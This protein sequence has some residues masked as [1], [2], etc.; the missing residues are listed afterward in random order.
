MAGRFRKARAWLAARRGR[1]VFGVAALLVPLVA[2]AGAVVSGAAAPLVLRLGLSAL[3]GAFD[4]HFEISDLR[5]GNLLREIELVGVRIADLDGRPVIEVDSLAARFR[6][7]DLLRKRIRVHDVDVWGA[8]VNIEQMHGESRVNLERIFVPNDQGDGGGGASNLEVTLRSVR[9]HGANLTIRIPAEA[10]ADSLQK[11]LETTPDGALL[12]RVDVIGIDAEVAE[13]RIRG[14]GLVGE[15]VDL[16][17]LDA[18][19]GLFPTSFRLGDLSG[20]VKHAGSRVSIDDGDV[21][22]GSSALAASGWVDWG[23][24]GLGYD[25]DLSSRRFDPADFRFFEPRLPPGLGQVRVHAYS[26]GEESSYTVTDLQLALGDSRLTGSLAV[27][28]GEELRVEG[29]DLEAEPLDL[30]LLEPWTGRALPMPMRAQGRVRLDGPLERLDV[31]GRFTLESPEGRFRPSTVQLD[32]R[33]LAEPPYGGF[34]LSV[35]A[36][37]LDLALV[38]ALWPSFPLEGPALVSGT[39]NGSLGGPVELDATFSHVLGPADT[40]R[41]R[42][43]GSITADNDDPVLNGRLELLGFRLPSLRPLHDVFSADVEAWGSLEL[44]GALSD[45]AIE[46]NLKTSAG[47]LRGTAR[48]NLMEPGEHYAL[49][50]ELEGIDIGAF[51][52]GVGSTSLFGHLEAEA[53]GSDPA[54]LTGRVDVALGPSTYD[55]L[56]V[57][58]LDAELRLGDGY[59]VVEEA[60]AIIEGT[61]ITADGTVGLG[62]G[63]PAG[64]LSFE[65]SAVSIAFLG[66]LLGLV[67]E[68][69]DEPAGT[70]EDGDDAPAGLDGRAR[71]TG[72]VFASLPRVDVRGEAHVLGASHS[73]I[74]VDSTH[75]AFVG[76]DVLGSERSLV[77][78]AELSSGSLLARAFDSA[79]VHADYTSRLVEFAVDLHRGEERGAEVAGGIMFGETQTELRLDRL[80]FGPANVRTDLVAPAVIAWGEEGIS[81]DRLEVA[82]AD[83]GGRLVIEGTVPRQGTVDLRAEVR[84][85][86]LSS[87]ASA[88]TS[89]DSIS[90]FVD[91][92]LTFSG[93]SADPVLSGSL[94]ATDLVLRGGDLPELHVS[95]DYEDLVLSVRARAMT[96]GVTVLDGDARIPLDLAPETEQVGILDGALDG[97]IR[98]RGLPAA[99]ILRMPGVLD[100]VTGTLDGDITLG[101]T[102]EAPRATGTIRLVD[103]G[104]R[105]SEMGVDLTAEGEF[106]LTGDGNVAVDLTAGSSGRARVRG[107][108]GLQDLT[109]PAFDLDIVADTFLALNRRDVAARVSGEA[110]LGGD[111]LQPVVSGRLDLSDLNL[112]LDERA[113]SRQV[114]DV[115]LANFYAVI[116]TM[117]FAQGGSAV[118]PIMDRFT[119]D[120]NMTLGQSSWLRSRNINAELEGELHITHEPP[121]EFDIAGELRTVRGSYSG[122]GRT[123]QVVRGSVLF[124]G[125][126][127]FDPV[128]DIVTVTRI[129]SSEQA[130]DIMATLAGTASEPQVTLSS[131]AEPPMAEEELVSY[132]VFGRPSHGLGSGENAVVAGVTGAASSVAVGMVANE[133]GSALGQEIGMFDYFTISTPQEVAQYGQSEAMRSSI[134]S[135]QVEFGQYLTENLFLAA[136]FRPLDGSNSFAGGRLEWT[137]RDSAALEVFLEDRLARSPSATFGDLGFTLEQ[138]LGMFLAKEWTY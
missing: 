96:N 8:T 91:A 49:D 24:E 28:T 56:S 128:L 58:S 12:Q 121:G 73:V 75:A 54:T 9:I 113:R 43:R 98:A 50:M 87:L 84:G 129:R 19:V 95:V 108:V 105:V 52:A 16:T 31:A 124:A 48:A 138:S 77:V 15:E 103:G 4:G 59:V 44:T 111:W 126:D 18:E 29:L 62:G 66:P 40:T 80:Q 101:G 115:N 13:A 116:D 67:D 65:A 119:V 10:D 17:R 118:T 25:L 125:S 39:V 86:A 60:R 1:W 114:A 64:D 89:E 92:D 20:S 27:H 131:T 63:T 120:L 61:R 76:Q 69:T 112:N 71:V 81:V 85:L 57:A 109:N 82:G 90:G 68:E 135:T 137:F 46:A 106:G 70:E 74:E 117:V 22:V 110:R 123:F 26:D 33:L 79:R 37:P 45:L 97:T 42:Y 23:G 88:S 133:L 136:I 30:A 7:G 35:E 32:G 83:Y 104:A 53:S 21:R 38:S 102:L 122:F 6:I 130:L 2:L 134:A 99:T 41:A 5:S 55:G 34:G 36:A 14:A 93:P 127:S 107:V 11:V 100:N 3:N 51:V 72:Q 78:D 132:L 94:T 47:D